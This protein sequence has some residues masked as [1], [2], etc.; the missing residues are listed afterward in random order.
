MTILSY[1]VP[2]G[3]GRQIYSTSLYS[4]V[5]PTNS[6]STEYTSDTFGNILFKDTGY[7]DNYHLLNIYLV[8]VQDMVNPSV[9]SPIL[10]IDQGIW[11]EKDIQTYGML[12]TTSDP[13]KTTGGGAIMMGHGFQ[14]ADDN[15]Q[16]VLTDTFGNTNQ[17]NAA[18]AHITSVDPS[19]HAITQITVSPQGSNYSFA[20]VTVPQSTNGKG[21][22]LEPIINSSGAITG[23]YIYDGGSGYSTGDQVQITSNPHDTLYLKQ[24]C[25]GTPNTKPANLDL[26]NLTA[27]GTLTIAAQG[28][29]TVWCNTDFEGG[30]LSSINPALDC[31]PSSG[32]TWGLGSGSYAWRGITAYSAYI[33]DYY[34]KSGASSAVF[35]G[36][37]TGTAAGVPV[38][39]T[40]PVS[41]ANGSIWLKS[42]P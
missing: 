3:T 41:P 18:Q 27:H 4:M 17:Q 19:T 36:N 5:L 10:A 6:P 40:D 30:I 32:P 29:L 42:D 24:Y 22:R 23:I 37:V 35:H 12:S 11:V 16:I 28:G 39:T 21:A 31:N 25:T 2:Q 13:M 7:N 34:D 15:P 20:D 1:N 38:L 9:F 14:S 8:E 33:N 26:Q